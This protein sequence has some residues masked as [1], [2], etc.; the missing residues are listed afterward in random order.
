MKTVQINTVLGTGSTGRIALNLHKAIVSSGNDS[1]IAY[2]RN[3]GFKPADN[4]AGNFFMFGD[5]PDFYRHVLLNFF[6]GKSG[7]G[8]VGNT[9]KL[10]SWLEEEK[11]DIIH[12]HNLHGF[13][14]NI[15]ILF[16]YIKKTSMP[17]VWTFHDCWP[18][19][20]QCA[21]FDYAGCNK[22]KTGCSNCPIYRSNY[23]YS[24]FKDNSSWNYENKKRIF[25][26]VKNL[27]IVTPSKW[28]EG[29][30]RESFLSD[31]PVK[32]IPNGIDTDTFRILQD[33]SVPGD[34]TSKVILSVANVWSKPKG[35]EYIL[36]LADELRDDPEYRFVIVGI[37]SSACNRLK[38]KHPNVLPVSR[39]GNI[40]ELVKLYNT[41]HVLLN[42]TMEDNFPTVNLEALSCGTPVLTFN[43]GGSPEALDDECGIIVPKGDVGAL[44]KALLNM[45]EFDPDTCR[46]K[47]LNYTSQISTSK[48]LDLYNSIIG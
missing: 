12:L 37:N 17:V 45:P 32:V 25:T 26:G 31:Y 39:T 41:A 16:E 28:L 42:P 24:L 33:D 38:K 11:P 47:A 4:D 18:F 19:T 36:H 6:K 43:T 40:D 48:Y 15:E 14:L 1:M 8:S 29:L 30:V 21:H 23:P 44:K 13:Y 27:T 20:G 9:R 5:R 10:I 34:K 35:L 3:T 2:G 22:W 7:F 46:R